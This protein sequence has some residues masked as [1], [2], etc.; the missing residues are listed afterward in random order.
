MTI[1]MSVR[2]VIRPDEPQGATQGLR[3]GFVI[4][5]LLEDAAAAA[6]NRRRAAFKAKLMRSLRNTTKGGS[7]SGAENGDVACNLVGWEG[8]GREGLLR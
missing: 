8:F 4:E 3:D 2:Q 7:N 6:E 1:S 5:Y